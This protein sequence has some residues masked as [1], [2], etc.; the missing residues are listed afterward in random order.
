MIRAVLSVEQKQAR[1]DF[2]ARTCTSRCFGISF[3]SPE[4]D[5]LNGAQQPVPAVGVGTSANAPES[6]TLATAT[7]ALDREGRGERAG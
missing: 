4:F 3:C 1:A 7:T 2:G 5:L 6:P